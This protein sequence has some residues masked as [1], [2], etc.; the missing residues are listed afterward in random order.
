MLP[1]KTGSK[2]VSSAVWAKARQLEKMVIYPIS[3]LGLDPP[4]ERFQILAAREFNHS[5]TALADQRV[6]VAVRG[7]N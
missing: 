7:G 4:D 3:C 2:S 5:V 1:Q 6:P